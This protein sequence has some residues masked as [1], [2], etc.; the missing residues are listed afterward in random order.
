MNLCII[1]APFYILSCTIHSQR[2]LPEKTQD[3]AL[4]KLFGDHRAPVRGFA[5]S[6]LGLST[7]FNGSMG[8]TSVHDR[9]HRQVHDLAARARCNYIFSVAKPRLRR[10]PTSHDHH[11]AHQ[12]HSSSSMYMCNSRGSSNC[13]D[14]LS[15]T[16]VHVRPG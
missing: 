16:N 3:R 5:K 12:Q 4:G 1:V 14:S 8:I 9:A 11:E 2:F 13:L 15:S 6:S 10:S 7:P